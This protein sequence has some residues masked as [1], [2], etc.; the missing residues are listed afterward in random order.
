MRDGLRDGR[1]NKG[2]EERMDAGH[3]WAMLHIYGIHAAPH[4]D[5]KPAIM[6]QMGRLFPFL[7]MDIPQ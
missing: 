7:L 4:T 5:A 1:R 6:G 3:P 2:R